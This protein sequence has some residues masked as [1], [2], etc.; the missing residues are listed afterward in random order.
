MYSNMSPGHQNTFQNLQNKV[1]VVIITG[2]LGPTKDD[3]TKKT[4]CEYFEDDLIENEA[5]LL[6]V[7]SIIEGIYKRPITQINRD[8]ALIPSTAKPPEKTPIN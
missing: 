3:I 6:H 5:V 7:R 1:D 8:Q 4:F 2:G